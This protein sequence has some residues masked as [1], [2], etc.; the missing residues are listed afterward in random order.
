MAKVKSLALRTRDWIRGIRQRFTRILPETLL[1]GYAM[2][3]GGTS[4]EDPMGH[5]THVSGSIVSTGAASNQ[6]IQGAAHGA[7]L[8]MEGLWSPIL[9]NLAP[10]SDFDKLF[11]TAYENGARVHSNSWGSASGFGE[12]DTFA[13]RVDEYMWNNPEMLI[14]F[15]AGNNG[16]DADRDGVIDLSS[17]SSPGTAKNVLTVGASENLLA[18]GGIQKQLHELRDGEKN[19]GVEPLRSDTLSNN[20]SGIAC[21]SSRGP[22][23]DGRLKPEIV[24]PGTNIVSDRSHHPKAQLLW[25]E[26]NKDY[27]YAGGTSMATPLTAGAAAVVR[28]YLI[29]KMKI[30][31][32]SA[33][34]VKA[35]L[36][37]TATDLFP[38]QYGTGPTQEIQKPR[39]NVQ[40][41]LR[42]RGHGFCDPTGRRNPTLDEKVGVALSEEKTYKL[43]VPAGA[44]LRATLVYTDA[45]AAASAS[46]ALVNDIDLKITSPDGA[47]QQSHDSVNN[48][49]MIEIQ[50]AQAG[51]YQVSVVGI[52]VPQGKDSHQPYA[53]IIG[54]Y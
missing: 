5:G 41:G 27:V 12:Y 52:N 25:G 9:D 10:S 21:F 4:W 19:W 32:P 38:G 15:A 1:K 14:L 35:T 44:R 6:L 7:R 30:D 45:P 53:L 48:S 18:Q 11:G 54:I 46:K 24:A 20:P 13:S 34:L 43:D 47:S 17:I 29:S 3:L 28:Q 51:T 8:V 31:T 50:N 36:M 22:T 49:E 39:P 42:T 2:G 26:F 23:A 16:V 40:E 37:H 33:S